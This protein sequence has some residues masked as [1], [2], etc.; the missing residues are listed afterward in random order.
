MQTVH[1]EACWGK[2]QTPNIRSYQAH[3]LKTERMKGRPALPKQKKKKLHYSVWLNPEQ[4][5]IIDER[6]A[7]SNLSASQYIL[8][9]LELA[10]IQPPKRRN[11]PKHISKQIVNLEKL[12]GMLA[13]YG[14]K[15]KDKEL[16]SEAWLKSSKIIR[17]LSE[18]ITL[19]VYE[20]FYI[21]KVRNFLNRNESS[22]HNMLVILDLA[23]NTITNNQLKKE[24]QELAL[25][26]K[27]AL[28][29]YDKYFGFE[30]VDLTIFQQEESASKELDIHQE[31][32]TIVQ[33][34]VRDL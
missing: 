34:I 22:L 24:I 32:K 7:F 14:L 20:E 28:Q 12:S 15:T 33:Q 19:W 18:L 5:R 2:P 27:E 1:A 21:S 30:D 25:L 9:Q 11:M 31:I 29:L 13:F 6:I 23:E 4:K 3:I 16:V 17:Y 26:N 8:T 10:P